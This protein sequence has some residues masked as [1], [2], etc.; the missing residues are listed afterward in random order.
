MSKQ[1]NHLIK[2]FT[3][4]PIFF[5]TEAKY[6]DFKLDIERVWFKHYS[7]HREHKSPFIGT[8]D[9][10]LAEKHYTKLAAMS[11][12]PAKSKSELETCKR[13]LESKSKSLSDAE[14]VIYNL[15]QII[16]N[17]QDELTLVTKRLLTLQ[18]VYESNNECPCD[19][20]ESIGTDSTNG[21]KLKKCNICN[22]IGVR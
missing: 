10:K 17:L 1:I 20:W 4:T 21:D 5:N 11:K 16:Y 6:L 2:S 8:L 3:I 18:E 15:N 19:D 12:Q 14:A 22:T 7:L 13:N 9:Y